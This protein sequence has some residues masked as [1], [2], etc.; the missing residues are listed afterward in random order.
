MNT[1]NIRVIAFD[2][3]D[4]LWDNQTLYDRTEAR[5]CQLLSAYGSEAEV[6]AAL[7][8]VE[9]SN[10]PTMGYGTK[11]FVLSL[12]QNALEMSHDTVDASTL[13]DILRMGQD[14]LLNPATPLDGVDE[15]LRTL[16]G[17]HRYQ[18]VCLTKG[19]MLD[20]QN[21]LQRSGLAPYFSHV[22]IVSEKGAD[23]YAS[24]FKRLGITAAEFMMVGNSF[25]SDIHPV[26]Q[27]GGIGIHVPYKRMW[28]YELFEEYEHERMARLSNI[29]ELPALLE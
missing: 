3:D 1:S 19:D 20:Q 21:K 5:Y 23:E 17:R 2:A 26:L 12:I 13:H 11:A 14:L 22:E 24:L 25:K 7:Y 4:T 16:Y 6:R 18:L 8:E 15:T 29:R 10:M 28:Q 9:K 27:L